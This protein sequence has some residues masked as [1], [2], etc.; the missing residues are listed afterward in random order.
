MARRPLACALGVLA[1]A[2]V[3][4]AVPA[5]RRPFWSSDEAR[6]ALLGQDVLD[7]GRWL[8]AEIRGHPYL[9]KPQLFF[10][11]VAVASAP[12]GRVTEL[13][14]ALPAVLSSVASVA[15]VIAIGHLLWGW[16]A[17]IMAGLVLATTPLSFEMSHQVLPDVMLN[18][19]LVWALYWLV[20]AERAAWAVRP[21]VAFYACIAV[22][23]LCKGPQA[24]AGL[25]AA[26]LAIAATDG[27][28]KLRRLRPVLGLAIVFGVAALVWLAPYQVRSHGAF[29]QRVVSGHYVTWYLFG[30]LLA[31]LEA[32]H[33]PLL[34]FLPWT[35]L[36]VAA[37]WWWRAN[38]DPA[39]RRIVLWTATLWVL[40]ALS[41]NY[42]SRYMLPVFPGLALLTAEFL[43]A[44]VTG[45]ARRGR[46]VAM[47]VCGGVVVVAAAATLLPLGSLVTKEDG[48]YLPAAAWEQATLL[49]LATTATAGL[50]YAV[51]AN[52]VR[53]GAVVLALALAAI[54]VLEGVM[55]PVRY[56]RAFD[57]RPLAAAAARSLGADGAIIGHPDLRLSYDVYLHHRRVFE[58]SDEAAVRARLSAPPRDA[59]IMTADRWKAL[60]PTA[61]PDWRVLASA[62]LR[63]RPMVAVGWSKP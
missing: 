50:L 38:P 44:P 61:H 43:T 29:E 62:K 5:G 3:I 53:T 10:W 60:A 36:L 12:F 58:M 20:R 35:V 1:L 16:P 39:R 28:A 18:A 54:L 48:A 49:L 42:R 2:L 51:R 32:L 47:V 22:G 45:L 33:E 31:R 4:A 24:L 25:L 40:S 23:L 11:A 9:N 57:V 6:F 15:G 17:G 8:V 55:Y 21:L 14:A 26:A 34:A 27:A 37:P 7:H 52:A 56:A 63:E 13:S 46:N 19:W 59:F 30:P 41:G